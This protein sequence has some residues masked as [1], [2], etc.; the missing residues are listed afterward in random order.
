MRHK[1]LAL[2]IALL[3]ASAL[4]ETIS[5]PI[6]AEVVDIRDGDTL[7]VIAHPWPAQSIS[8]GVRIRGIDA[9]SIRGKCEGE[10]AKA[11]EAR[12]VLATFAPPGSIV[13]L[14]RVRYGKYAHRVDADVRSERGD[15]REQM[16]RLKLVVEY[17]GR[18]KA[19]SWCE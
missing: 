14:T 2:L 18:T 12:A 1:L 16:L 6:A 10:R 19:P 5:G 8:T 9:P 11:L 4:A 15:L 17:D 7:Q 3:P 13:Q